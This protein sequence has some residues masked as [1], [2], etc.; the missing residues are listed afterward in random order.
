MIKISFQPNQGWH[1]YQEMMTKALR[2]YGIDASPGLDFNNK[3][4]L[5]EKSLVIHFHWIE[6]LWDTNS[7]WSAF[8]NLVG[9]FSYIRL[10]KKLGKLVVWTVHNHQPHVGKH[11][12]VNVIGVK[13]I[14]KSCD[15]ILVHSEW[16]KEYIARTHR[17]KAEI[18]L[19]PHGNFQGYFPTKLDPIAQEIKIKAKDRLIFGVIGGIRRNR[20]Y[21]TVID[22]FKNLPEDYVLLIAGSCNDEDY[23]SQIKQHAESSRNIVF[24]NK[25]LT[26]AIKDT[27]NKKITLAIDFS[28]KPAVQQIKYY[29][30]KK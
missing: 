8:K 13:L 2:V 1:A 29:L 9:I 22:V 12:A 4:L 30:K 6:R 19:V 21:S 24:I 14:A 11:H 17:P 10:A 20:G 25:K 7:L 15:L 5:E 16:S 27:K 28:N 18:L 3:N 23:L 26:D